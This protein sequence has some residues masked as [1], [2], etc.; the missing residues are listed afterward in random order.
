MNFEDYENVV[1]FENSLNLILGII[2]YL[3]KSDFS[4]YIK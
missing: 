3:E 4:P 2:I 1:F